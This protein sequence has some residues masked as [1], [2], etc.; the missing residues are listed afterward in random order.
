MIT[1]FIGLLFLTA[2]FDTF[3]GNILFPGKVEVLQVTEHSFIIRRRLRFML[4]PFWGYAAH[5]EDWMTVTRSMSDYYPTMNKAYRYN[6]G[7]KDIV[8]KIAKDIG[9]VKNRLECGDATV[10]WSSKKEK[11]KKKTPDDELF[12]LGD[13]LRKEGVKIELD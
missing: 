12:E 9:R 1:M 10:V 11:P 8:I 2:I 13:R 5:M 3:F 7:S 4:I 6:A